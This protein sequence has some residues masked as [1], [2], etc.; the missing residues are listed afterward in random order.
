MLAAL[1]AQVTL[2]PAARAQ[3]PAPE[4]Y[5]GDFW[6]RPRLTGDW[7]GFRDTMA[8][9]GVTLDVDWL[10]ILQ[11]VISGGREKDVGY[12][13]TFEYTLNLDTQKMGLWPGGFLTAYGMSSYG[14]TVINESGALV[15]V[16]TA[17]MLPAV[18][19]DEPASALM[20]LTFAQFLAPWVGVVVGKFNSLEGDN[21]D[22]AHD[23]R[24]QFSN[25]GLNFNLTAALAPVSA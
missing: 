8:K 14:T 7:G 20:K 1:A 5:A 17:G 9:K 15:P 21:N 12:W 24:T 3:T 23:Y 22:F 16:N 13:G 25:M 18:A 11:G 10:Q 6:T 19:V 2:S 4:T